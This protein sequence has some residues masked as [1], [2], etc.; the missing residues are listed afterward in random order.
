MDGEEQANK[1]NLRVLE[2]KEDRTKV[3]TRSEHCP[4]FSFILMHNIAE[5]I[6]CTEYTK[7]INKSLILEKAK[8]KPVVI[9]L[10]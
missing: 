9:Q 2:T 8:A 7:E 6:L 5:K 4:M 3:V 1:M 10:N